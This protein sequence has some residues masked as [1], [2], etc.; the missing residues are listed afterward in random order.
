MSA[1]HVKHK[2]A[3]AIFRPSQDE[4]WTAA[5]RP[6]R[7]DGSGGAILVK[8]VKR[9]WGRVVAAQAPSTARHGFLGEAA[10]GRTDREQGP[11]LGATATVT[12]R[13]AAPGRDCHPFPTR[14]VTG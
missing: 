9:S 10:A 11:A 13:S 4:L 8:V 1:T 3:R 12:A 6:S 14:N 5:S 2:R 7:S